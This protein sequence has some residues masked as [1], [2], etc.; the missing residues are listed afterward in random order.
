M[1]LTF[2]PCT[3]QLHPWPPSCSSPH[4]MHC[5]V[6][7]FLSSELDSD[8]AGVQLSGPFPGSRGHQDW[9]TF[10]VV[11]SHALGPLFLSLLMSRLVYFSCRLTVASQLAVWRRTREDMT[12]QRVQGQCEREHVCEALRQAGPSAP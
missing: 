9:S 8:L 1:T 11:F 4:T 5:N 6:L 2:Q 7:I 10:C 3:T 12:G